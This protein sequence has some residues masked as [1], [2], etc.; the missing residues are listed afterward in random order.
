MKE[1]N[2]DYSFSIGELVYT[3]RKLN[4]LTQVEFSKQ[5]GVVQST[6][7]KGK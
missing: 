4:K 6:I 5:V 3:V 1:I 7:S 2:K